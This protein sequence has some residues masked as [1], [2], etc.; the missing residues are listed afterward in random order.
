MTIERALEFFAK[1]KKTFD[2]LSKQM[3][4]AKNI[5]KNDE[6]FTKE[7]INWL[8]I[9]KSETRKYVVKAGLETALLEHVEKNNP[10]YIEKKIVMKSL[11]K[12]QV[13]HKYI[14]P[15]ISYTI[16]TTTPKE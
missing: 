4:I 9:S 3:E 11:E 13:Y 2:E 15:S 1:N 6:N 7:E 16:R 14:E 5:I 10:E 12:D 8:V